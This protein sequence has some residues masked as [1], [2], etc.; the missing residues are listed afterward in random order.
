MNMYSSLN[1]RHKVVIF[2]ALIIAGVVLMNDSSLGEGLGVILI[3]VCF[4]W[5][6]GSDYR[7]VYVI[8]L[9]TG[10]ILALGGPILP[11]RRDHQ[12]AMTKFQSALTE[13]QAA[14]ASYPDK[15]AVAK[16]W[17][18]TVH[19]S[20]EQ[21]V[22]SAAHEKKPPPPFDLS[23]GMR[24]PPAP[25]EPQEPPSFSLMTAYSDHWRWMVPG[26]LFACLGLGLIVGVKPPNTP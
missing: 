23:E 16:S 21:E 24:P 6:V 1:R 8:L 25:K 4:A 13:Y 19:K 14:I 9:L 17:K 22:E 2:V 15:V 20:Y 11:G 26:L 18:E 3:G 7:P 5:A 12:T 10:I